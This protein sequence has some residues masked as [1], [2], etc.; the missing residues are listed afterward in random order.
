MSFKKK[1]NKLQIIFDNVYIPYFKN[2]LEISLYYHVSLRGIILF[3][4]WIYQL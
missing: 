4:L 2:Y 1:K 3:F